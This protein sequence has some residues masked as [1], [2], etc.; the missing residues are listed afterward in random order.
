MPDNQPLISL[1]TFWTTTSVLLPFFLK[2]CLIPLIDVENAPLTDEVEYGSFSGGSIPG[3]EVERG[4]VCSGI[5]G[6]GL[7]G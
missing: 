1:S 3:I 7:R 5:G 4:R 6:C 2:A